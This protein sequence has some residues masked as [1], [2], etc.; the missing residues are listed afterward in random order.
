M[1]GASAIDVINLSK[2]YGDVPAIEDLSFSVERGS[3]VGFLGPNG[4]GKSTTMRVLA[5]L[6]LASSGQAFVEGVSV[7]DEPQRVKSIIGYM[8]EHNPLPEDLR[9]VEYLTHR[10]HLKKIPTR[11]IRARVDE[12]MVICDLEKKAR[13]KIIKTLS[14]GYRQRVGIADAILAR[15]KVVIMDE[16]TIGLDPHQILGMRSL[17]DAL[18]QDMTVLL[19]SHILPEI[20]ASCDKA[21]IINQGRIVAQGSKEELQQAFSL[22]QYLRFTVC[23]AAAVKATELSEYLEIPLRLLN[24][25]GDTYTFET[26]TDASSSLDSILCKLHQKHPRWTILQ[27]YTV[28]VTM[29]AIFLAATKRSWE[30]LHE[31]K[32]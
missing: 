21:I 25:D 10:A 24:V 16:P 27:F 8:P 18:R 32:A 3:I 28:P 14:K 19:S 15:P 4:A 30:T 20:E 31:K 12:V 6:M 29:E 9:V 5:G 11:G 22:N 7:A 1:K 26:T 13:R 17:L 2:Y 23:S